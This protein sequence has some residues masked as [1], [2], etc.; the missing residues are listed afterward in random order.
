MSNGFPKQLG[1][2]ALPMFPLC[3]TLARGALVI[4]NRDSSQPL[5]EVRHTILD[6]RKGPG[7][8]VGGQCALFFPVLLDTVASTAKKSLSFDRRGGR[9]ANLPASAR[10]PNA[11]NGE[12]FV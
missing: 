7:D 5:F 1:E 2:T 12:N 11:A 4:T 10:L 9:R 6:Q 3:G 8:C